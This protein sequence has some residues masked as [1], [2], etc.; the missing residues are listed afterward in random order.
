MPGLDTIIAAASGPGRSER[1]IVRISGPATRALLTEAFA[2]PVVMARRGV[3]RARL[4]LTES[5]VLP[6]IVL[7]MPGPSSYTG[8]DAAEIVTAGNPSLIER[9]LHRLEAFDS[10]RPATPGEFSA[11][12]YL[13]GRLSIEQAE[14]VAATIAARTDAQLDAAERL[15]TG[16][17]GREYRAWADETA[18]LLALVEAGIDFADQEDVVAISARDLRSRCGTLADRIDSL[19]GA[20]AGREA[21]TEVTRVVLVGR[22][23][24][25]K[26]TLFNALLGRRRAVVSAEPG[27]TRDVL[28]EPLDLSQEVPGGPTVTLVDLAGLDSATSTGTDAAAQRA[29]HMAIRAAHVIIHCDPAGR[30]PPIE[31]A[32]PEAAVLR[33]R[34]KA[35]LP[36]TARPAGDLVV[37]ALDGWNLA[38]LRRAIADAAWGREADHLAEWVPSRHRRALRQTAAGLRDA[39]AAAEGTGN[40]SQMASPEL[41][42]VALRESL[43][44]IGEVTG[45]IAPDDVIGRIFATFCIG[46]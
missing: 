43:D 29:A 9:V 4:R 45:H 41:A 28:E 39:A 11:R 20:S 18:T 19:L 1:A 13:G 7:V 3:V 6:V 12:A 34:T 37:C 21:E 2:P 46:K 15:L 40:G 27:T 25:G 24:A 36:G 22:P 42:A 14:G 32:G 33:I 31:Q 35:D 16:E 26:S 10:V 5:L 30:F 23:N 44:A 38:P 8:E 17:R